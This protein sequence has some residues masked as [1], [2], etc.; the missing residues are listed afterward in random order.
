M[1]FSG[2]CLADTP[3]VVEFGISSTL[4]LLQGYRITDTV[5][6]TFS[7]PSQVATTWLQHSI[8]DSPMLEAQPWAKRCFFMAVMY[9]LAR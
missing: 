2:L 8:E 7:P 3:N 9:L 5:Q 4:S 6:S 1:N